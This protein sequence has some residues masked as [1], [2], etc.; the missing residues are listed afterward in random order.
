MAIVNY[1]PKTNTSLEQGNANWLIHII[2]YEQIR[3][4]SYVQLLSP[5]L[6]NCTC[7]LMYLYFLLTYSTRWTK[8]IVIHKVM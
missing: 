5:V 3:D 8:I 4:L 6:S 1:A 2:F 7:E